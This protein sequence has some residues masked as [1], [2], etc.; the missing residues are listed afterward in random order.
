MFAE[1]FGVIF[2]SQLKFSKFP[3]FSPDSRPQHW[4]HSF[5]LVPCCHPSHISLPWFSR[6]HWVSPGVFPFLITT[7]L[8]G[9]GLSPW[10][11]VLQGAARSLRT[12]EVL[13]VL[14]IKCQHSLGY[15]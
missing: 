14:T 12:A 5:P 15:H 4:N 10:C 2:N 9:V 7:P 6:Q 8:N 3:N 13:A 1:T 11:C